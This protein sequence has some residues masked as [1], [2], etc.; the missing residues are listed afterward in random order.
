MA[1]LV[2]GGAGLVG[3]RIVR[4]LVKEGDQV[5]TY[6]LCTEGNLLTQLLSEEEIS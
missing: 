5:I 6:D 3:S 2:T 4:D 1:Y